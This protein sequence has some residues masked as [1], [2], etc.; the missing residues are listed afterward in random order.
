[1][2]HSQREN[3]PTEAKAKLILNGT[4]LRNNCYCCRENECLNKIAFKNPWVYALPLICSM[5]KYISYAEEEVLK[6][7]RENHHLIF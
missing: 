1:M 5:T 6:S 7:A 2:S 3:M 4:L